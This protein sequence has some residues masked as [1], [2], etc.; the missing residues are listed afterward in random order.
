MR[1]ERVKKRGRWE[2][3]GAA[4]L[5][6]S[7]QQLRYEECVCVSISVQYQSIVSLWS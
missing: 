2:Q 5:L 6:L 3:S 4:V 7:L 1:E